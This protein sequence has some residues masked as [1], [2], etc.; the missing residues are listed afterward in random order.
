MSQHALRK[1]DEKE[2]RKQEKGIHQALR[3]NDEKETR[4]ALTPTLSTPSA[5]RKPTSARKEKDKEGAEA[6][7]G[8]E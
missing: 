5:T 2:V 7:G 1:N 8:R 3:K 6:R 4:D